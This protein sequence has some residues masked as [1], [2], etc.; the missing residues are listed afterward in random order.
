MKISKIFS[1][2]IS[3]GEFIMLQMIE[4]ME[5]ESGN[6][7]IWIS[8]IVKRV[9]VTPQAVSKFVNLVEKKAFLERIENPFDHRSTGI[10]F[11]DKGR[12]VLQI[13]SEEMETF[14]RHVAEDFTEEELE[15]LHRLF[16]KLEVAIQNNYDQFK[17]R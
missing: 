9:E 12:R 17:K 4:E 8:D 14:R 7:D 15:T 13:T 2:D 11:T 1:E 5:I 3:F 16:R 10:R 6:S